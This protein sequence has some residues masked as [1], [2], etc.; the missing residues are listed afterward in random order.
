MSLCARLRT[1]IARRP[2]PLAVTSSSPGA[3]APRLPTVKVLVI[4]EGVHDIE[5]LRRISVILHAANPRLADLADM[6]APG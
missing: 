3:H 4:V 2:P 1:W 6:G 5:F